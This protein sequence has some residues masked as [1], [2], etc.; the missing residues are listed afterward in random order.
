MKLRLL[1]R[2]MT[3]S[4]P[5]MTVQKHVSL[6]FRM[7]SVALAIAIGAVGAIWAW[8]SLFGNAEAEKQT[9]SAELK[10]TKQELEKEKTERERL[11]EIANKADAQIKIERSSVEQLSR[12]MKALESDN[13]KLLADVAYLETLLPADGASGN[14]AIRRLSLEKE[15][16]VAPT[17]P[18]QIR[19][20]ALVMQ[21][22]REQKEFAGSIQ[23]VAQGTL[24]GKPMSLTL[25]DQGGPEVKDRMKIAFKRYQRIEGFIDVPPGAVIKTVQ[26]RLLEKGTLRAQ[27][28]ASL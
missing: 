19:Y 8:Q 4:A 21:G 18:Q 15:P 12:Q 23:I 24:N 17:N 25:P 13:G 16:L 10:T 6:P 7:A 26:L 14:V 2:R 22:G 11:T 28:T 5:K 3:V 20:K 1:A 9:L 27:E